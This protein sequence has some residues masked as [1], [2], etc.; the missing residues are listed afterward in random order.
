MTV[1]RESGQR[2]CP[3][4][5][6]HTEALNCPVDGEMT[7]V[8]AKKEPTAADRVGQLIGGRYK[9][10][11]VIGQGGFGAVYRALHTATG[12]QVAIKVLRTDV[13]G[14]QDVVAR[15]RQEAKQTSKLKH[16]NTVRVF[17]FGQMDDGNLFLAME[18]LEGRTLSELLRKES[19]LQPERLIHIAVQVLKALS[20]A[21]AKGLVHRDLKPDNIFL[22]TV[23]G[24]PDFVKVLDFGI[25]KSVSGDTAADMTSTGAIIGTPRYM[26]PEQA[27]GQGVDL[28]TDLYSLAI[29]LHEGLAGTTPFLAESPLSML[30]RRVQEE[31][32]RVHE[33]LAVATPA[34]VCDAVL[35]ALGREA[36]ERFANADEMAAALQAGLKTETIAPRAL[37]R[38]ADLG[39]GHMTGGAMAATGAGKST[40]KVVVS[41]G[42]DE[43][44]ATLDSSQSEE[45]KIQLR[46]SAAEGAATAGIGA[47]PTALQ[48]P[49]VRGNSGSGAGNAATVA[50][51]AP[52]GIGLVAG[53]QGAASPAASTGTVTSRPGGLVLGIGAALV[54]TV[55]V[56]A[57]LVLGGK[58]DDAGGER[59][60]VGP[61]TAAPIQAAGVPTAGEPAGSGGPAAPAPAAA[62]A[63]Q[64]GLAQPGIAAPAAV[65]APA[66]APLAPAPAAAQ[67]T[68]KLKLIVEPAD[69]A[70]EIDGTALD[71]TEAALT[72]GSHRV[73]AFKSGFEEETADLQVAAGEV[74]TLKL[75]LK[76]SAA[77]AKP[78]AGRPSAEK[79]PGKGAE[80]AA[81]KGTEKPSE[82]SPEKPVEKP[83]EKQGGKG[84][85]IID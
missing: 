44:G 47:L 60:A 70:V 34:G 39:V 18:F 21:H 7:L 67:G 54:A 11:A 42:A 27:K 63:A 80:K 66:P 76:R 12:D 46:Q 2:V 77:G 85:L 31:P 83:A 43:I 9:I 1:S 65:P 38:P 28:R 50:Q 52:A 56:L 55:A 6:V 84:G 58:N 41:Q 62:V 61:A 53:S 75:E 14:A 73:R 32:P 40:G 45:L 5:G 24:E 20:E 17:D 72:P 4:C 49:P 79:L 81:E 13:Q 16:P 8:V 22:Q 51:S 3:E 10:Q 25:A 33:E 69:A 57:V 59:A 48:A 74:H 64:P 26:S 15:F 37:V 29:I 36:A 23:H 35:K 71:G 78:G 19:P 68:A 30:L 82:K